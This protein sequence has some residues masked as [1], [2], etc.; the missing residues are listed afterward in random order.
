MF[1]AEMTWGFFQCWTAEPEW[2]PSES[3]C[4]E[5]RKRF[6]AALRF[7]RFIGASVNDFA[8][9]FA[10]IFIVIL[11]RNGKFKTL[12]SVI[13]IFDVITATSPL[14]LTIRRVARERAAGTLL[15]NSR[16]TTS[17][18]STS[19]CSR[20]ER[21][22]PGLFSGSCFKVKNDRTMRSRRRAIVSSLNKND[23]LIN[24]EI[25]RVP[26]AGGSRSSC[27]STCAQ[28]RLADRLDC[29]IDPPP[30]RRAS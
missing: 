16:R 25:D 13:T 3:L 6:A 1:T 21:I 22:H 19:Q 11:S 17:C 20:S 2:P 15:Q 24:R 4:S 30:K 7:S 23:A 8:N 28:R 9:C 14:E 18:N 27:S 12:I 10:L 5:T 29:W 26:S